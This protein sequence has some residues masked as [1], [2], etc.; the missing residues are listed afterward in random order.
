[1]TDREFESIIRRGAESKNFDY[2]GPMRWDASDIGCAG[3]I[4]DVLAMANSGGGQIVIGVAEDDSSPTGWNWQ[5]VHR[6]DI[7]SW[8]QT[9][10]GQVLREH[11]GASVEFSIH[12]VPLDGDTFVVLTIAPF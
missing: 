3:L 12:R 6:A 7:S 1:M 2:K 11:T 10:F 8:D 9:R 4:A 5:G